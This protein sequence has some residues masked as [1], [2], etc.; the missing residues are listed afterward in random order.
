MEMIPEYIRRKYNS[1]LIQYLDPRLENILDQSYGVITYQDDVMMISIELAGYSWLEADKLRKA[2][3]KKIPELMEEQKKKLHEGFLEHGLSEEKAHKLWDLIEPFAAY[4]FNKAHAASYGRVAYQTAYLKANYP[5][6]YM[7]AVLT[8]E[9]KDTEKITEIIGE[10]KRMNIPVLP[11]DVNESF[12]DFTVIQ[13]TIK[14]ERDKIRFGLFSIKNLGHDISEAI[15]EEREKNGAFKSYTDFLDRVQHH[16]MNKR[17]LEALIQS[18]AL[19]S[20]E[21]RSK[22]LGNLDS[23]LEYNRHTTKEKTGDQSSLFGLMEDT[24]SLPTFTLSDEFEEIPKEQFLKWEKELL[25]VYV[26]GHPLDRFRERFEKRNVSIKKI[27]EDLH[28]GMTV[29]VG[30]IV[31]EAKVIFTKKGDHMAFLRL[32]DFTSSIETVVFPKLFTQHKDL[33]E[34][35]KCLAIKGKISKRN[36]E[37]SLIIEGIKELA[38]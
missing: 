22:M 5:A 28:E 36:G 31:E 12:G 24:S 2:M 37:T 33:L 18:G 23:S 6:E 9:A 3:G 29:V 15:Q 11:P 35:D 25:G 7:T 32:A 38:D 26:S 34:V 13:N 1:D 17:S 27:K 10:C 4:G 20:L 8:A 30:G 21:N 16:N 14:G 19:D